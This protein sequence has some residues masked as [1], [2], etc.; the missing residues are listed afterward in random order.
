MP[1]EVMRG[2]EEAFGCKILE[3]YGL[4][5][6]LAGRLVQPP[7]Q[8]AQA[9]LDRHADRGRRDEARRRRRQRRRAQGEVGEIAIRGHNVMK[10]YWNR[11]DATEEVMTRRLVPHRRHGQ[12]RRGRLLLHRRPQEGH[13]HPRRLQ[14]LPARDRGGPLRAPGGLRGGRDRRARRLDGRGGRRRRRAQGGRGRRA[15]TTSARSSRSASPPTSTRARSGSSTSCPRARRARS[16]SARSRCPRR[17]R[18][19]RG[20]R[21]TERAAE[22]AAAAPKG[23]ASSGLDTLLTDAARGPLRRWLPGRGGRQARRQ[24][25]ARGPDTVVAP[26]RAARRASWRRSRVGRSDVAPA[27]GR[28]P[29][30]GRRRGAATPPSAGCCRPT[31]PR[32]GRSTG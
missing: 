8:G 5:R 27:Q 21:P 16:S 29:L 30:Q 3:G 13:D 31:S 12:G 11:E 19:S 7:R 24:A 1:V 4:S 18:A 15:P 25:G 6:D 26:R 28:P 32:A 20:G 22:G 14:R 2:F 23:A 10:G 9:R 17:S